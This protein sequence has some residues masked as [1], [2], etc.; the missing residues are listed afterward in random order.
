MTTKK[1][2]AWWICCAA[3][4]LL[5]VLTFTPLVMPLGVHEP[6]LLGVPYTLWT[7]ILLTIALVG[8]TYWATQVYP[9]TDNRREI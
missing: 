9:P 5:S 3:V 6:T 4:L 2:I 1:R 7:S 8:L